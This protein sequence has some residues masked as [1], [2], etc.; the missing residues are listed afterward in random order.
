MIELQS[1]VELLAIMVGIK[2]ILENYKPPIQKSVQALVMLFVG[3]AGGF[4]LNPTKEGLVTG[5]VGGTVAFWGRDIFAK[6]DEIKR[7]DK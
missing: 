3:G 7:G 5:L 6:V 2:L 1:I 4:L